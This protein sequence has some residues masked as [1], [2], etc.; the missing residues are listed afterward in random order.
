MTILANF[1][2]TRDQI[3][4]AVLKECGALDGSGTPDTQDVADV[5]FA[6][7]ILIKA[8]IK[9]GMPLWKVV[10]LVVPM[11]ANQAT[12]N[13]GPSA[14]GTGALVTDKP[15]R[16]LNAFLRNLVGGSTNQDLPL[17]PLSRE[18]YAAFGNKTQA[19]IPNSFYY[20]PLVPNGLLTM[21]PPVSASAQ[22]EL[23]L[24]VQVPIND[25]VNAGDI[26]DFPAECY[27][28]LKWNLCAEVGGQYVTSEVKLRR[29]DQYAAKYKAEMENWSQE[30]ASIYMGYSK[31]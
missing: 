27:Q 8:W 31:E 1:T 25:I 7:N 6:L 23:H 20:Q 4:T 21:Y 18:E 10:E 28:A 26:P 13:I 11:L 17:T 19:S 15:L 14:T 9:N 2:C 22:Y 16:V 29:I 3:V 12:Y 5:T 30:E 24:Y